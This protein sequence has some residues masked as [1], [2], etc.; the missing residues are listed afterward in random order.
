VSLD[1]KTLVVPRAVL[2]V[3][4]L[5]E[6]VALPAD[7]NR[8]GAILDDCRMEWVTRRIA[9]NNPAFK[10]VIPYGLLVTSDGRLATYPR[11]GTEKRLHG[12]L[13]AGVGGHCVPEDMADGS[14]LACLENGLLREIS[15]EFYNPPRIL[16]LDVIGVIN[17][18]E[19]SVGK[20]HVGIVILVHVSGHEA[21]VPAPEL[22]GLK[23]LTLNEAGGF[24]FELW[25]K[26][27]L[28]LL[29]M[30]AAT[31]EAETANIRENRR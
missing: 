4:W 24:Q 10:Q 29:K 20:T 25:S 1:E 31:D 14:V 27:A 18:E 6:R 9:E 11:Q 28:K 30:Q 7:A 8:I 3:E 12:L 13:S 23:W 5:A 15:E 17:E 19:T 2:P 21:A 26:L 22:Q 16:S